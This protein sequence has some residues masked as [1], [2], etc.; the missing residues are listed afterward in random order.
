[1]R[2]NPEEGGGRNRQAQP[3]VPLRFQGRKGPPG[4]FLGCDLKDGFCGQSAVQPVA[5]QKRPPV[6]QTDPQQRLRVWTEPAVRGTK[7]LKNRD[8]KVLHSNQKPLELIERI[9]RASSDPG[10]IIWEPF[11]GLCPAAVVS[12]RTGRQC[13]SAETNP[14]YY[15]LAKAR[16]DR[17]R[18]D[19]AL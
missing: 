15:R 16:I 9:I 10:D 19:I 18:Q 5:A 17:E 7:R 1:M 8:S 4:C 14:D 3:V 6:A 2:F 11:G 13:Y 12:L